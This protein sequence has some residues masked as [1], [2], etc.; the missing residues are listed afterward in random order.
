MPMNA[1]IENFH[2]LAAA[3]NGVAKLRELILSLAV[4]GKLVPQDPNDE[5]ASELLKKIA[6]EKARLLKDGKIKK[7]KSLSEIAED[8]KPYE[9]PQGW[10]WV[11]LADVFEVLNGRAYS[12]GELLNQGTPVLRVGNLFTS[13]HWY[14]SNLSLDE[15]KYCDKD[16]LLF[17]WSASFGPF[18]WPGPKVIYHYHIW[19]LKPHGEVHT[20][21]PFFYKLLLEKT[22]EIKAA[23]HGVSMAHMT[24]EK[25]EKIALPIPPFAE[26]QRIVAKVDELMALCDQLEVQQATQGE[27]HERLVTALLEALTRSADVQEFAHGWARLAEHFELLFD[28]PESIAKLK[29]TVLQLAVQ[30]KLVPQDPNDE[31]ASDLLK[32][33][34]D[35]KARLVNDEGLRTTAISADHR[36]IDWLPSHWACERL[37]NL[38]KFIDYRGRTPQKVNA[39]IPLITAKN[40]RYGYIDREPREFITPDEYV[41]WMTRGFPR[42]GDLLFTT[43]APL[44]NVALI[45][46]QEEFALAQRVVCFQF[47]ISELGKF[48]RLAF[49]SLNMQEEFQLEATGMT[50]TGIKASRLKEILV[51]LPPLAE[52]QRIVAKVDELMSL[53]N[54][55]EIQ[56]SEAKAKSVTLLDTMI[57]QALNPS[58]EIIDLARYRAAIGCYAIHKMS[59]KPYFGRTAAMKVIYMAEVDV[60]MRLQFQFEREAAGPLDPWIY[61]FEEEGEREG[62]FKVVESTSANGKT[63]V[64][65][66][67]GRSLAEQ[68]AQAERLLTSDQRKELDRLLALL[69]DKKTEEV[70]IVATLFAAW[71]DFLIDGHA[72]TDDEIVTEVREHWHEKKERF[73]PSQL[74]QWLGWLRQNN[75]VP[76]GRLPH[77]VHQQQLL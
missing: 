41:Q 23:G 7:D 44:G 62:W 31:P 14:Y 43:E 29:Q 76:R 26:Q 10:E 63:K 21:K 20:S 18:I 28:T 74:R 77:T 55:L 12:K 69:S 22:Q 72:P 17:A 24:K 19:K 46:I 9:L 30:G 4:R 48:L 1:L 25:M 16:D 58:A 3:P 52:Q 71:N 67:P 73:T 57:R 70:E 42:V 15:D 49:M 11:R 50:A 32:K 2:L 59:D 35:E 66:Q 33:I 45:D 34:A 60:G 38:A 40:V 8:E 75:L 56:L 51:P 53:C 64:Q 13:N 6:A 61:R 36:K 39:G 65:Y 54:L 5:P 47:H 27:A 37:G 68:A